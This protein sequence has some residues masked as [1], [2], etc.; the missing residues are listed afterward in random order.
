MHANSRSRCFVLCGLFKLVRT[1]F[2]V[3]A[4]SH[5]GGSC[6]SAS[7]KALVKELPPNLQ[8]TALEEDPPG[9]QIVPDHDGCNCQLSPCMPNH[10]G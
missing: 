1:K 3:R 6:W 2:F 7:L 9:I 8:W 10:D 4:K 5:V